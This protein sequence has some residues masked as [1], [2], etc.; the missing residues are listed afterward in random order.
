MGVI[1]ITWSSATVATVTSELHP[2]P[3]PPPCTTSLAISHLR[4]FQFSF[5]A[6]FLDYTLFFFLR[7]QLVQ[8]FQL[9][10]LSLLVSLLI[11]SHLTHPIPFSVNSHVFDLPLIFFHHFQSV[12]LLQSRFI[13][14]DVSVKL[15]MAVYVCLFLNLHQFLF[16]FLFKLLFY[17][18]S[19]SSFL[20]FSGKYLH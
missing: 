13:H 20:H 7:V 1:S 10:S 4:L 6:L 16:S 11:V 14:L 18:E 12:K 17:S 2:T 3:P 8:R 15:K 5:L 9:V 19:F